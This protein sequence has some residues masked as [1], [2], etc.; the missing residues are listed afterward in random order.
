MLSNKPT[1]ARMRFLGM[2][3]EH[4]THAEPVW[5]ADL[6]ACVCSEQRESNLCM[7]MFF[8]LQHFKP[9][10]DGQKGRSPPSNPPSQV[11]EAEVLSFN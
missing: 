9:L 11:A 1:Q 6:D 10:A 8:S 7:S 5:P 2:T 4:T 3:A